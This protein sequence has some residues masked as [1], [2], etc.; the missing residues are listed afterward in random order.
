MALANL[1]EQYA[2]GRTKL[3]ATGQL[4]GISG[5]RPRNIYIH[6]KHIVVL[7]SEY[8]RCFLAGC[9]QMPI[10]PV[11]IKRAPAVIFFFSKCCH[12]YFRFELCFGF[13]FCF[14]SVCPIIC[15]QL[16]LTTIRCKKTP[17]FTPIYHFELNGV[18]SGRYLHHFFCGSQKHCKANQRYD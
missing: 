9:I 8:Q 18:K 12:S 7:G 3:S 2:T 1:I 6:C 5:I 15:R 16:D 13:A 4:S 10:W 17:F 11:F 14:R